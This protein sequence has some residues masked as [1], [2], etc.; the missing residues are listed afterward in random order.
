MF[1]LG[2]V[3]MICAAYLA[4]VIIAVV[5]AIRVGELGPWRTLATWQHDLGPIGLAGVAVLLVIGAAAIIAFLA[6]EGLARR[7][8]RLAGAPPGQW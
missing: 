5:V 6:W 4:V 3:A 2:M 7:A 8:T 1:L